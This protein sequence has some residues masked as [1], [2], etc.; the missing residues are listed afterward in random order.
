MYSVAR[1]LYKV[2]QKGHFNM[3]CINT[4]R[5]LD[6]LMCK[7]DKKI[8]RQYI[9]KFE[10]SSCKNESIVNKYL[11]KSSKYFSQRLVGI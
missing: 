10:K 1:L 7:T 2:I 5:M 11:T 4:I 6:I 9:L 3:L 8:K